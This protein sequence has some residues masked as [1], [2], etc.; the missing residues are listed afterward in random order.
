[1]YTVLVLSHRIRNKTYSVLDY[2]QFNLKT[3]ITNGLSSCCIHIFR[4][5]AG[6]TMLN[7]FLVQKLDKEHHFEREHHFF[8]VAKTLQFCHKVDEKFVFLSPMQRAIMQH[9]Y[10]DYYQTDFK[11]FFFLCSDDDKS[12]KVVLFICV[13]R[14]YG[15]FHCNINFK[16]LKS[17]FFLTSK[18]LVTRV[19]NTFSS[20]STASFSKCFFF[21]SHCKS[22]GNLCLK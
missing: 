4:W 18:G 10:Q 13:S 15:R 3:K 11:I 19:K 7:F 12:I 21:P 1:M 14:T 5:D 20:T 9:R 8:L 2:I 6:D 16:S 22:N 17:S